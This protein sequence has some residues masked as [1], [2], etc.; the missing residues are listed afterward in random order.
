MKGG[1]GEGMD[2]AGAAFF[3][4]RAVAPM[5]WVLL[6]LMLIETMVVH[7]LVALWNAWAALILSI[8]SL[9]LV[10]WFIL[11]LR[12]LKRHPVCVDARGLTWPIGSMRSLTIPWRQVV[13]VRAE[14]TLA[15]LRAAGLF[16]GG[17]IAHPNI[18]VE[19]DPPVQTRRRSIR[20]LAHRL[21]EPSDFVAAFSAWNVSASSSF[22]PRLDMK[23]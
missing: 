13:G 10:G 22:S 18:V 9:T 17:L 12:S 16:N 7:L 1:A 5:L 14:W 23:D 8:M 20:F 3:Y 15:E 4:H 21:D 19:L 6:S 2:P 11:F